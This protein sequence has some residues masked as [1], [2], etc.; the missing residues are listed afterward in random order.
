MDTIKSV[1]SLSLKHMR[2]LLR[3]DLNVPLKN[4]KILNDY[5]LQALLPTI[6][7]IK[8]HGG[9]IILATHIGRPD[10][11]S[12]SNFF[13]ETLS[14]KLLVPWF[15][16]QGY[17]V[18]YEVDLLQAKEKSYKDHNQILLLENLRFF[19]GEKES[20]VEFAQL[21]VDLADVYVN[22]AFALIHRKDTSIN[23]T[24]KKFLPENRAAGL[25]IETEIS[26]LSKIKSSPEQPFVVVLGGNKIKDK[27]PLLKNLITSP[28][29]P[30]TIVIGGAISLPFL[31]VQNLFLNAHPLTDHETLSTTQK[32]LELAHEHSVTIQLPQDAPEN[33]TDIGPETIQEFKKTI[34]QAKTI[35]ANGTMGIYEKSESAHGTQEILRAIADSPAYTIIGGGDAASATHL[36]GLQNHMNFISTGGGATLAFLAAQDPSEN[37]HALKILKK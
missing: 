28:T 13:D 2:V 9:K 32:I 22:D 6:D 31:H 25:L 15:E 30:E 24:P 11:A 34:T 8:K 27:I 26:E 10:A 16:K 1:K 18:N 17:D 14:T 4:N 35:F 12:K 37:L 21:L 7:Y 36:F 5:R 23:I 29:K 33:F 3:A 19:N 20:C